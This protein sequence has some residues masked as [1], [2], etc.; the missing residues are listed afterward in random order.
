LFRL[1]G[2]AAFCEGDYEAAEQCY[3]KAV[4]LDP[5]K[6][7]AWEGLAEVQSVCA[8]HDQAAETYN[9]LVRTF[10]TPFHHVVPFWD[11]F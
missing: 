3:E 11:L 7:G 9:H 6:L 5:S 8:R 4:D 10:L 1:A 2:K